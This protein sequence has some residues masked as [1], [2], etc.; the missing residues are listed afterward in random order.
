MDEITNLVVGSWGAIKTFKTTF[1]LTFPTPL[2]HLDFDLSFDRA[3]NRIPPHLQVVQIPYNVALT[4]GILS[5]GD[6]ISKAYQI[7]VKFP[8][9]RIRGVLEV[10]ESQIIPD[11]M[12]IL[13]TP[14][15]KS[16]LLDTG[17]IMWGTDK[18]AQLQRAQGNNATRISLKSIEYAVPNQEMRALLGSAKNHGKN[19]YIPHHIGGVYEDVLTTQ[20]TDSIRIGDT[21]DGWSHLGAIVDVIVKTGRQT[22]ASGIGPIPEITIETCGYTLSAE[23]LSIPN[24]TFDNLLALINALRGAD[25]AAI[26]GI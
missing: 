15:I 25:T 4:A 26:T 24:P 8:K 16:L 9:Q 11:I 22:P 12:E 2:V 5:Q 10:W 13:G 6:V 14:R 3:K 19:L 20:G 21:W 7:P 18:D 23:G 17:T 1:G